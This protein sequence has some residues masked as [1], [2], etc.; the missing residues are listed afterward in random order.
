MPK[1][2]LVWP[3]RWLPFWTHLFQIC[4]SDYQGPPGLFLRQKI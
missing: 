2:Q 4:L 1:R 3:K